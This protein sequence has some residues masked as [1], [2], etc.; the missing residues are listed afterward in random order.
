M[1]LAFCPRHILLNIAIQFPYR[2]RFDVRLKCCAH[3]G[4]RDRVPPT[5]CSSYFDIQF[6]VVF[7]I[8]HVRDLLLQHLFFQLMF[9][10]VRL[11]LH[12]E[13]SKL[14]IR[15]PGVFRPFCRV[16]R[17]YYKS[18]WC[19]SPQSHPGAEILIS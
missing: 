3:D 17:Q 5:S 1:K 19:G 18:A 6:P 16:C 12:L 13:A 7:R 15:G 11:G 4:H 9:F 14:R 8:Y 2:L 10:Q